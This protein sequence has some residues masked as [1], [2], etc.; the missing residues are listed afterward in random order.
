MDF[1]DRQCV[2]WFS[3]FNG[4]VVKSIGT[5]PVNFKLTLFVVSRDYNAFVAFAGVEFALMMWPLSIVNNSMKLLISALSL[6]FRSRLTA[7]A[8]K[9]YFDG[10]TFYRV[11]NIDNRTQNADQLLTQDIDKF[12]RELAHL[13]SDLVSTTSFYSRFLG[14]R[15]SH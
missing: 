4:Q 13:Y 7:H 5:F 15:A 10:I 8:H 6:S 1:F 14:G 3:A 2:V 12:S 11:S 9:L